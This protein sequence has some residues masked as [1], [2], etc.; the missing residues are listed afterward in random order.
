MTTTIVLVDDHP[1]VRQGLRAVLE[2][3]EDLEVVA[4]AAD[5]A[6]VRNGSKRNA[7]PVFFRLKATERIVGG[8][9]WSTRCVKTGDRETG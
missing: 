8:A 7:R 3:A 9:I 6:F 5:G 2:D 4:E 1:L